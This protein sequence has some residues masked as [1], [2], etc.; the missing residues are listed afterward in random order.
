LALSCSTRLQHGYSRV[1]CVRPALLFLLALAGP[2]LGQTRI[3]VEAFE[4]K[5][6]PVVRKQIESSI[7]EFAECVPWAKVAKRGKPDP[8]NVKKLGV[9]YLVGG[10]VTGKGKKR[11]LQLSVFSKV[12][13]SPQWKKSWPLSGKQLGAKPLAQATA[14]LMAEMQL[15]LDLSAPE[16]PPTQDVEV[17]VDDPDLPRAGDEGKRVDDAPDKRDET[18]RKDAPAQSEAKPEAG[19]DEGGARHAVLVADVGLELA[20]KYFDYIQSAKRNIRPYNAPLTAAPA[21]RLEVYPLALFKKGLLAGLG[22]DFGTAIVAGL[23]S[24]EVSATGVSRLYPTSL[25]RVEFGARFRIRPFSGSEVAIVPL[26]GLRVHNFKVLPAE[27]G[28]VIDGLPGIAYTALKLGV[29]G[30]VPIG[31]RLG[32]GAAFTLMPLLGFGEIVTVDWFP[33]GTGFGFDFTAFI[34]V[35]IAGPLQIK[36]AGYVTRYGLAFE[37]V[38]TDTYVATGAWD[39]HAGGFFGVRLVF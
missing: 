9:K 7:C 3:C 18:A 12:P 27:D 16:P 20:G 6:A 37:T 31:E 24:R 35:K 11:V 1:S 30:E 2:A 36:V 5:G 32:I 14:A 8:K 17:K 10:K 26:L 22:I 29:G 4:G 15:G 34:T 21:F 13:G 39:V 33:R 38:P 25:F 28:S 23:Q 19:A